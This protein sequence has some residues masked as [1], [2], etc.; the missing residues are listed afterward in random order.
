MKST[1][2]VFFLLL[3]LSTYGQDKHNYNS[4]NRLK[5]IE[6][7]PYVLTSIDNMGKMGTVHREYLV[8]INTKTGK[9]NE[10]EFGK[11]ASLHNWEQVKNDSLGINTIV[12]TARTVTI[13]K[14][15]RIDYNDPIQV[16]VLSPDGLQKKQL[17]DDKFFTIHHTIHPETGVIVIN[18]YYDSNNNGKHDKTDKDEIVLF[19]LKTWQLIAKL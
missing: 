3:T 18:G 9:A 1:F 15:R 2:P 4:F 6:G 11:D 5:A 7:T 13:D 19:D 8:F 14:N 17:T 16:I 10:A 12:L